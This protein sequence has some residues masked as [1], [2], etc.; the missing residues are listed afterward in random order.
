MISVLYIF[1][2]FLV[3]WVTN[4]QSGKQYTVVPLNTVVYDTHEQMCRDYGGGLTE[5]RSDEE[6]KYVVSLMACV[7]CQVVLG[8][9][10]DVSRGGWFWNSDGDVVSWQNWAVWSSGSHEPDNE[11]ANN[12]MVLMNVQPHDVEGDGKG[13]WGDYMCSYSTPQTARL[14]CQKY[15]GNLI[16]NNI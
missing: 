3:T 1:P 9:K 8:M 12:C 6:N 14:V 13:V 2:V 4:G 11:V 15:P 7:D 5:P 16:S 10:Y